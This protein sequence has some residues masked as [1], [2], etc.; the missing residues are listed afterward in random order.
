MDYPNGFE[1]LD[2]NDIF[3]NTVQDTVQDNIYDVSHIESNPYPN[4]NIER[5]DSMNGNK[6]VTFSIEKQVSYN[7]QTVKIGVYDIPKNDYQNYINWI[8]QTAWNEYNKLKEEYPMEKKEYVTT[9]TDTGAKQHNQTFNGG[10]QGASFGTEGQWKWLTKT[11]IK[12]EKVQDYKHMQK[13]MEA[14]KNK[15]WDYVNQYK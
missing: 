8:N 13:I 10:N 12:R 11:G 4:G 15:Q 14:I 1:D 5:N 7:Y 6:D 9:T 3:G 2:N